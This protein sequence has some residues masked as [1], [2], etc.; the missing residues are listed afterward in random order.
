[1]NDLFNLGKVTRRLSVIKEISQGAAYLLILNSFCIR[2]FAERGLSGGLKNF[3]WIL[4]LSPICAVDRL[5]LKHIIRLT[6]KQGPER[7]SRKNGCHAPVP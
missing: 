3:I 1:M 6:F 5:W 7:P 4:A 2:F